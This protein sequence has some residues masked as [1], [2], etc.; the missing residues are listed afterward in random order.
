MDT[1]TL[2]WIIVAVVVA[3]LILGLLAA[4]WNKKRKERRQVQAGELRQDA[5]ARAPAL[6]EADLRAR[7]AQVEADRARYEAEHAEARAQEAEQIR[8]V[9]AARQEDTIR[10]ADRL[11]PG[12]D[13]SSEDYHPQPPEG[14]AHRAP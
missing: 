4:L 3:L 7:E 14:G 12:V 13:T 11:D 1:D 10:E 8:H 5:A 9:Q 6:D 2:I